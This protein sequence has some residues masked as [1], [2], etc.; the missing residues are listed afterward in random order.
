MTSAQ[1]LALLRLV[2]QRI[3]GPPLPGAAEVVRWLTAMQAQDPRGA[4]TSVAL[5]AAS[6]TRSAVEAAFDAG[7]VV[8]SWPMRGTLHLVAAE[9]LPWLLPLTTPRILAN[10]ATRRAQ[11]DI[12]DATIERAR[13]LAVKALAGGGR[14]IRGELMA[15]WE[16]GGLATTGQRGYHLLSHLAQTGLLCFGP[17]R[18]GEQEIVLV[19]EWIREPRRLERDEALG[20]LALRYFLG[21][22]PATVKDF[23]RWTSLPAADVRAGLAIAR[24][25]LASV[26]VDGAVHL[27]DPRTPE[28]LAG[29]RRRA[30]GVFLLPGFDEFILGYADRSAMVP[31]AFADRIVPGGNGVF[32]PTVVSAGQVVGLWKRARDGVV[33]TPFTTFAAPVATAIPRVYARLPS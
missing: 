17:T 18:A 31:P 28:L 27:M 32:Q 20:E 5:R 23:T 15:A 19:E 8:K 29:G 11:L 25:R 1:D 7:E 10:T 24:P 22:G 13:Q 30:R 26:E 12:D 33:A 9:D 4:V 3:A 6:G 16:E 2:A 14:L 21:H